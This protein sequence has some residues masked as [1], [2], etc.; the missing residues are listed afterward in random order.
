MVGVDLACGLCAVA[1]VGF[2]AGRL[3]LG[4]EELRELGGARP[5]PK[6]RCSPAERI[7]GR[8]G[9]SLM[10]AVGSLSVRAARAVV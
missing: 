8:A 1:S 10:A 7:S 3:P 5:G 2:E 6:S 4:T 9:K